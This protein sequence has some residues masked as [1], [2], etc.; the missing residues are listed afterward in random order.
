MSRWMRAA[1]DTGLAMLVGILVGIAMSVATE[2]VL[3]SRPPDA[4]A[5]GLAAVIGGVLLFRRRSPLGVLLLT[6][7]CLLL[8]YGLEYPGITPAVPLALALYTA[9][10]GGLLVWS[11]GVAALFVMLGLTIRP[12]HLG[13]PILPVL[14]DM[15]AQAGLLLAVV[16][17]GETMRSRRVRLAEAGERLALVEAGREREAAR[18]AAEERLRIAG[19]IHD[20]LSHTITGMTIQAALADEMLDDRPADARTALRAIRTAAREATIELRSA[21]GLLRADDGETPPRV[22]APGLG[23]VGELTERARSAGLEATVI[24][25]GEA[26]RLPPAV[27]LAAFRVVQESV[28]NTIRHANAGTVQIT[29][30]YEPDALEVEVVDDGRPREGRDRRDERPEARGTSGYGLS[31]MGERASSLGGTL[32]AAPLPGGGFS[33]LVRLPIG[34]PA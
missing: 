24:V 5:Y 3:G 19:D 6:A 30:A 32:T 13:E 17:L 31:G 33:V 16:L 2:P 1:T 23:Q 25:K 8:Y 28:T 20:V 7:A 18:R 22:P 34:E 4:I 12:L 29:L 11:L 26:R 9:A 14:T 15:T 27:D 10:S 21:L